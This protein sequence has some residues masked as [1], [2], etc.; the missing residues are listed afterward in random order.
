MVLRIPLSGK[1]MQMPVGL[2]LLDACG[3]IEKH[4]GK[5]AAT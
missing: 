5:K 3:M 2:P 4:N 1:T